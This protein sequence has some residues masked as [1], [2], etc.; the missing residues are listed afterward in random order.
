MELR[1]LKLLFYF[2]HTIY[3]DVADVLISKDVLVIFMKMIKT[4]VKADMPIFTWICI[5]ANKPPVIT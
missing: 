3:I 1:L 2:V 4:E 5:Y